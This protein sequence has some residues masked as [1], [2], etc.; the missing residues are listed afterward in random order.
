MFLSIRKDVLAGIIV[1][2]IALPLCLGIAQASGAPL[3]AGIISG[4]LGGIVVG[5]LSKSQISVSG[6]AAGLIA[7]VITAIQGLGFETFLCAIVIAGAIQLLLGLIRAGTF[8]NYFPS[9]VIEGMMA[10]IGLTI[11][12]KELPN[13]LGIGK[14]ASVQ[15]WSGLGKIFGQIEPVAAIISIIGVALLALWTHP[16]LRRLA[17][18]PAGLLVV[19][20]GTLINEVSNASGSHLALSAAHL[21]QLEVPESAAAFLSQFSLPDWNGFLNPAV[22]KTGLI[23]AV[24]ASI[25]TLLCIEATD[26][27]DKKRRI[28]SGNAELRAQGIG[29]MLS[30]FI[31]GLPIT[32]VIVRSSANINAGAE[33]KRATIIHGTLLLLCAASIPALLNHIPKAALSAILIFTGYRLCRPAMIHHMWKGGLLRFLPFIATAVGVVAFDLLTGVGIG[34]VLSVFFMLR[35]NLRVPFFY[36]RSVYANGDLIRIRL[37]QDVSFLNKAVLVQTLRHIPQASTLI[38]DASD[39]RHIDADVVAVIADFIERRAPE[40]NIRVALI[41]FK[42]RYKL[43]E[44]M[45]EREAMLP[46]LDNGE[47]PSRTAGNHQKL[48]KQ[49]SLT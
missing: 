48:L 2:L 46:L 40:S 45:S 19:V 44:T 29:N 9:S 3:F 42:N 14:G 35:Q 10:G 1:F 39:S 33:T 26:S 21:V 8:A 5:S 4:I 24:V 34:L 47:V 49:L 15:S 36:Q 16:R 28:T 41:G 18:V 31:G 30:G 38:I 20:L 32:S 23:I 43:P 22:W 13:A 6:P 12:L 37:A 27:L 11:I 17:L 7:I 25:E